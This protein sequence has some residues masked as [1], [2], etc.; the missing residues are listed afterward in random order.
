MGVGAR[1]DVG[2]IMSPGTP[3]YVQSLMDGVVVLMIEKR[4]TVEHLEEVLSVGG[5]DMVQFG[6]AD[7]S[8]NIGLP[9]QFTH[10]KVKEA[11][12]YTIETAHRMGI[13]ARA[14]IMDFSEADP[15]IDMGVKD[16]CIGVDLAVIHDY[17]K[18]QGEALAKTLGR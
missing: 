16:F 6:P 12:K 9:G 1:R 15:Y 17:C 5:V 11:E 10:P 18:V 8:L 7:Y 2:Y 14:E 4:S 13:P 3:E